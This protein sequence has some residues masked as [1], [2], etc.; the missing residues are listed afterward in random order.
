[1][2][3]QKKPGEVL[4]EKVQSLMQAFMLRKD[5]CQDT[6][7]WYLSI[8]DE[9]LEEFG[10]SMQEYLTARPD[11]FSENCWYVFA[12][13]NF[14]TNLPGDQRRIT[15]AGEYHNPILEESEKTL[16][17]LFT[18]VDRLC[19]LVGVTDEII[20]LQDDSKQLGDSE[21]NLRKRMVEL[22]LPVYFGLLAMGYSDDELG[23]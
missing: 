14:Y 6:I 8:K 7:E 12:F 3:H 16:G 15:A 11:S 20:N 10:P 1:M 9:L 21:Y 22:S 19:A 5:D 23:S 17:E 2:A 13:N 4:D 18:D